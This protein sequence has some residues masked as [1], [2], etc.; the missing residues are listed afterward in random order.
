MV[1]Y[2]ENIF[3]QKGIA[4]PVIDTGYSIYHISGNN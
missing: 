2:W 1:P 3:T 4:N